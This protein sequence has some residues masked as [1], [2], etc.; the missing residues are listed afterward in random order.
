MKEVIQE[1]KIEPSVG[2]LNFIGVPNK[3]HTTTDDSQTL[4]GHITL[5]LKKSMKA[6][7]MIV[8]FKGHSQ[9]H[10]YNTTTTDQYTMSTPLLPK[11]KTKVL[12]KSTTFPAGE[13]TIPW[14]LEIPN[15][16]ARSFLAPKRGSI[17][18]KVELKISFGINKKSMTLSH[19]IMLYRH[20][21]GSVEMMMDMPTKR[22]E[23]TTN[24]F[25]YAIEAPRIVSI[26]Q[27][28]FPVL[29]KYNKPVKF[30]YTQI[31]QTEIYRYI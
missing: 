10:S 17:Q 21:V 14:E 25:Q 9:V 28:R 1:I 27:E 13:H 30:I 4:R 3:E 23:H 22:F 16:Y 29:I 2:Y 8:K 15:I 31:I 24:K 20:L 12:S 11:L 7:M 5:N 18:Y 26:D 6:K 19:P